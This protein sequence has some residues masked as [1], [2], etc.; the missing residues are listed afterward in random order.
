MIG[1]W[2]G[3]KSFPDPAK[4]GYITAPL[5]PGCYDLRLT[6]G[7]AILCGSSRCVAHRMSSLHP[8]G[9]GT[10]NNNEKRAFV[11]A[12]LARLE[13]RTIAFATKKEALACERKLLADQKYR[14]PT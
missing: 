12:N 5:G 6:S 4:G 13:Y 3:W 10:R 1:R 7:E 2:S 9:A 8:S 14:F 11:E